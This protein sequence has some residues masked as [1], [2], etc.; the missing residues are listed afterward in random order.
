MRD[1]GGRSNVMKWSGIV[2]LG[3]NQKPQDARFG[4]TT[5]A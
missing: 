4:L 3:Y 2:P 1:P 5:P